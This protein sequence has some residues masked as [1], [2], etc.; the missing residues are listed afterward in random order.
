MRIITTVILGAILIVSCKK[1][2]LR[3]VVKGKVV[4]ALDGTGV[5]NVNLAVNKDPLSIEGGRSKTKGEGVSDENGNFNIHYKRGFNLAQWHI[6]VPDGDDINYWIKKD[7]SPDINHYALSDRKEKDI[8]LRVIPVG[9]VEFSVDTSI[10]KESALL[11]VIATDIVRSTS[12]II[13]VTFPQTEFKIKLPAT[14]SIISCYK[15]EE[16]LENLLVIDTIQVVYRQSVKHTI[17]L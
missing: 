10:F 16:K 8:E 7:R 5:A 15:N 2:P 11:R 13:N 12:T 17:S 6:F 9:E 14:T 3:P 1:S 4:S